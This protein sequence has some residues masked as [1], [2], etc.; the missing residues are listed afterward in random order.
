MSKS[1]NRISE[2]IVYLV[3]VC[4]NVLNVNALLGLDVVAYSESSILNALSKPMLSYLH[5]VGYIIYLLCILMRLH[6][7]QAVAWSILFCMAGIF[8]SI[9]AST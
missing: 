6:Q 2:T 3:L 4:P 7:F 8:A 1:W 9:L 5:V